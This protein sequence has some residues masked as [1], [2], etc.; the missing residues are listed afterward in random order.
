MKQLFS[1]SVDITAVRFDRSGQ[2]YPSRI[3]YDGRT[4]YT[5]IDAKT[6]NVCFAG[7]M[8]GAW[9]E[10]RGREWYIVSRVIS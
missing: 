10:R 2:S 3:S 9:L 7:D 5:H 1:M 4:F 6:G 8:S